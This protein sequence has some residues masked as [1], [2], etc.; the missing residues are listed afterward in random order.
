MK[1]R[2]RKSGDG[3][4]KYS[5]GTRLFWAGGFGDSAASKKRCADLLFSHGHDVKCGAVAIAASLE[6]NFD[7]ALSAIGTMVGAWCCVEA[8]SSSG[9]SPRAGSAAS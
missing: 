7:F 5:R 4:L 8:F 6:F 2:K 9:L 3:P 1:K